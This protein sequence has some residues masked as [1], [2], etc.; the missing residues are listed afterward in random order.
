MVDESS[1]PRIEFSSVTNW[2]SRALPTACDHDFRDSGSGCNEVQSST[3]PGGMRADTSGRS[4]R[5]EPDESGD[6]FECSRN[7]RRGYRMLTD[8][9][10]PLQSAKDEPFFVLT[11][12]F[13]VGSQQ[14]AIR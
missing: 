11:S 9:A 2:H 6:A 3:D 7:L 14:S 8:V 12:S 1:P 4:V 10:I 13:R 5:I